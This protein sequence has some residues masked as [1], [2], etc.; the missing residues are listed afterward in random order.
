MSLFNS[1]HFFVV[2][3]LPRLWKMSIFRLSQTLCI[4]SAHTLM[5]IFLFCFVSPFPVL[6]D[7]NKLSLPSIVT[8]VTVVLHSGIFASKG[9][10][11]HWEIVLQRSLISVSLCDL[12]DI[13][14][15]CF[16]L[17]C[18]T[19]FCGGNWLV[20]QLNSRSCQLLNLYFQLYNF[21]LYLIYMRALYCAI[22]CKMV[23]LY[24]WNV[25]AYS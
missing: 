7:V 1:H 11:W 13:N 5:H 10:Q 16:R 9:V 3:F 19:L 8:A 2:I 25:W 22:L 6:L 15:A 24:Q 12:F 4:R 21:C 20:P 18:T 14:S 23:D 17:C